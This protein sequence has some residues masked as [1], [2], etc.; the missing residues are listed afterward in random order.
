MCV[1]MLIAKSPVAPFACFTY[2]IGASGF[3]LQ[4]QYLIICIVSIVLFLIC[5]HLM[6]ICKFI[7]F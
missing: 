1:Q 3:I 4:S 6:H 2:T 7:E 5:I